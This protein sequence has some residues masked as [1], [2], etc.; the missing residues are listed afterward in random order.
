[1][2]NEPR[3]PRDVRPVVAAGLC[4]IAAILAW[5]LL[6][7]D[8]AAAPP[9]HEPQ[10]A[11]RPVVAADAATPSARST[12]AP[13]PPSRRD[14]A[15]PAPPRRA[16][17]AARLSASAVAPEGEVTPRTGIAAFPPPGTDPPKRGV[18][19][20]DDFE[21]PP[22][23]V[24]HYQTTDDGQQLPAILMFHPDFQPVDDRGRP[25]PLPE[26]RVV[27]PELAPP[28]L[29]RDVLTVPPTYVPL[30]EDPPR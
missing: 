28:G 13:A 17:P 29:A 20:P 5:P 3:V 19:V 9:R 7:G 6:R 4:L 11:A 14:P 10:I 24:R 27:P 16:P 22:G 15:V 21:L 25:I 8:D 1:M 18:V 23:Y 2:A 26:D 12:V 30:V